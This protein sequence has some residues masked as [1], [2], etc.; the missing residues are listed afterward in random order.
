MCENCGINHE[1]NELEDQDILNNFL[2]RLV[3]EDN[4]T[5]SVGDLDGDLFAM[6][7]SLLGNEPEEQEPMSSYMEE[8]GLTPEFTLAGELYGKTWEVKV[9]EIPLDQIKE[10]DRVHGSQWWV[11]DGYYDGEL[12]RSTEGAP[13]EPVTAEE[14]AKTYAEYHFDF[15]F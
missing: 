12:V 2:A 9:A 5:D 11:L 4:N 13:P 8:R 3:E 10:E 15:V 1:T 14:A 7:A 6:L